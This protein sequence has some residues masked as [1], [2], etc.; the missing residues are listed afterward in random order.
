MLHVFSQLRRDGLAYT[1]RASQKRGRLYDCIKERVLQGGGE[2]FILPVLRK[3][4]YNNKEKEIDEGNYKSE[5][6]N[7]S[8]YS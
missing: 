3:E 6:S 5:S 4:V 1:S 2:I 7:D 8:F